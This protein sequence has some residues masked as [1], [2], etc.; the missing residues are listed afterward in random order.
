MSG[1]TGLEVFL[2]IGIAIALIGNVVVWR[3]RVHHKQDT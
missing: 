1:L 2:L 3:R